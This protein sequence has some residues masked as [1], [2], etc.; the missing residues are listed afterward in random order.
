MLKPQSRWVEFNE[1][2]F[3]NESYEGFIEVQKIIE[4]AIDRRRLLESKIISDIKEK[5]ILSLPTNG[6]NNYSDY[7]KDFNQLKNRVYNEIV[8]FVQNEIKDTLD[9]SFLDQEKLLQ[10]YAK[11]QREKESEYLTQ[12]PVFEEH[13]FSLHVLKAVSASM[14]SHTR[15][16]SPTEKRDIKQALSKDFSGIGVVLKDTY[17]GPVIARV[18]EG[19]SAEKQ[20]VMVDDI[21][22]KIDDKPVEQLYFKE[23]LEMLS[24]RVNSKVRLM[25]KRG[26]SEKEIVVT[27]SRLSLAESSMVITRFKDKDG[28]VGCIRL[29]GFYDN[30]QGV[31]AAA[32]L[33]EALLKFKSEENLKGVVLDLRRNTGGF[34]TQAGRVC[35]LFNGGGP[36]VL[37]RYANGQISVFKERTEKAVYNGPLVILISKLSA[38]ASEIVAQTLKEYGSAIIVGDAHSYGK[39]SMQYQTITSDSRYAYAVTVA[40]YYTISGA[41]VQLKGVQSDIV[42]PTELSNY[43]IG[44]KYLKY[45]LSYDSITGQMD[46]KGATKS[47]ELADIF[48][49][50]Q[51]KSST[52]PYRSL[53]PQLRQLAEKRGQVIISGDPVLDRAALVAL[54]MYNLSKSN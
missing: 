48:S 51:R 45:P 3:N 30:D 10:F 8:A 49:F 4:Q 28:F 15:F 11:K 2:T 33:K 39:G 21:I 22:L 12:G 13:F 23:V 16:F 27:R 31:S 35:A 5:N 19:S 42:I 6:S 7:P 20:G 1:K 36:I 38:S 46:L 17:Q 53:I 50:Y 44:E 41:S 43:Q 25:L 47:S 29:D 26:D 34:L 54:D 24:G 52:S 18:I 40:K 14:D 9:P 37:A 32:Q